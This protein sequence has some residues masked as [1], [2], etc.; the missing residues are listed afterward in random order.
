[1]T[2]GVHIRVGGE[3]AELSVPGLALPQSAADVDI[4][5]MPYVLRLTVSV[6]HGKPVCT[7]LAAEMRPGGIPVTRRGLNALPIERLVRE[8]AAHLAAR[9]QDGPGYRT[10]DLPPG[11]AEADVIRRELAR[12]PGR[13]G[14]PDARTQLVERVAQEYKA[15]LELQV[16]RQPKPLIAK[17]LGISTSYVG[18]LLRE[19]RQ[20]G[21]LGPA[22]PGRA[23]P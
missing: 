21:I 12:R 6:V 17:K 20:R 4:P 23:S 14:D 15:L 22:V 18:A 10:Y 11:D 9:V 13:R 3:F 1:V 19:A 8:V 5:D 2:P 7:S 16:T